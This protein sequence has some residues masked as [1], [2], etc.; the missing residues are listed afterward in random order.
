MWKYLWNDI[1][2]SGSERNEEHIA[3][4][5]REGDPSPIRAGNVAKL[6]PIVVWKAELVS[7]GLGYLTEE[8]SRQ[9][10]RCRLVCYCCL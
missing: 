10:S 1:I 9:C 6:C 4:N 7:G 5:Q 8:T 3:G 2:D